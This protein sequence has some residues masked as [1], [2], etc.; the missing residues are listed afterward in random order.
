MEFHCYT[1][2][3]LLLNLLLEATGGGGQGL[4]LPRGHFYNR[5]PGANFTYRV[6]SLANLMQ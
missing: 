1:V 3:L 2:T 5:R 6:R 4:A